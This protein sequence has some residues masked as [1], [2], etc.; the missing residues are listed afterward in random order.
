MLF[1][2]LRRKPIATRVC[3]VMVLRLISRNT[4][5]AEL[6]DR[7]RFYSSYKEVN[8][9]LTAENF[10]RSPNSCR[11]IGPDTHVKEA[12]PDYDASLKSSYEAVLHTLPKLQRTINSKEA[13]LSI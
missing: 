10:F 5:R 1:Y 6:S 7:S 9:D 11:I 2:V 12:S 13:Y 8:E 3:D 4:I